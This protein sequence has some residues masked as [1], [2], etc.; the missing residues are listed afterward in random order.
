MSDM[1]T[2]LR[3]AQ[4]PKDEAAAIR[5]LREY[6]AH[7]SAS[8]AGAANIS[9]ANYE[10][11]LAALSSV[12][13]EP[14]GVLLLAFVGGEAAGCV[15]VK[16]RHDRPGACEMKRLWVDPRQQGAGLG[17]RLAQAAIDWSRN[18]GAH[19]LLL[20]TVPAA[21]PAAVAL[22]RSLGFVEAERHNDNPVS[23]LVFFALPLR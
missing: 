12:W 1:Q 8:P 10:S 3:V 15:A 23:G 5:L 2:V 9:I 18:H 14:R 7:L 6:A 13:T 21:M 16:I 19:V 11:E 4:W 20:D 17:R 22:Y